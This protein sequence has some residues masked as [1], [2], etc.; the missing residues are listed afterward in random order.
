[1]QLWLSTIFH[2]NYNEYTSLGLAGRLRIALR[3]FS[4]FLDFRNWILLL[5]LGC[6]WIAVT[7]KYTRIVRSAALAAFFY[8]IGV[9]LLY[10][11]S[12]PLFTFRYMPGMLFFAGCTMAFLLDAVSQWLVRGRLGLKLRRLAATTGIL[13]MLIAAVG[14]HYF[15]FPNYLEQVEQQ[16]IRVETGKWLSRNTPP[17]ATIAVE[18]IG[19]IGFY[20]DRYIVDMGGLITR[21]AQTVM[22][23]GCTSSTDLARFFISTQPTFVV[24]ASGLCLAVPALEQTR[25]TYKKVFGVDS[26]RANVVDCWVYELGSP[27]TDQ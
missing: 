9:P 5:S 4:F 26:E 16:A 17:L 12:F 14:L 25:F 10:S 7:R 20:A 8:S 24:D 13:I 27:G 21:Q 18:P 22:P 6:L 23:N 19:A 11:L 3:S 2:L 1:M 15:S